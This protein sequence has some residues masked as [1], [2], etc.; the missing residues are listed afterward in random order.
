MKLYVINVTF[1][2]LSKRRDNV[3]LFD[4]VT[5]KTSFPVTV[6]VYVKVKD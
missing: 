4:K 6:S 3:T 2:F 1:F 5:E